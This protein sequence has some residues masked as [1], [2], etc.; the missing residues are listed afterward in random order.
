MDKDYA[1]KNQPPSLL[2]KELKIDTN[3]LFTDN[4]KKLMMSQT[5][6]RRDF[7]IKEKIKE[8]AKSK[9]ISE[10]Q[11]KKNSSSLKMTLDGQKVSLSSY[12][13]LD[14]I[15]DKCET[16]L[17]KDYAK[18]NGLNT[19]SNRIAKFSYS[20][21]F[22]REICSIKNPEERYARIKT[23]NE[24]QLLAQG[25]TLEI[26]NLPMRKLLEIADKTPKLREDSKALDLSM[27]ESS[28]LALMML[29]EFWMN[30]HKSPKEITV[31][32]DALQKYG[33]ILSGNKE[34][35]SIEKLG[36]KEILGSD[37]IVPPKDMNNALIRENDDQIEHGD[38]GPNIVEDILNATA[39]KKDLPK[40][41]DKKLLEEKLLEE[42]Q[43]QMS[44]SI[45]DD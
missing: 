34:H 3:K 14:Y 28:S 33:N 21:K 25:F 35:G 45:Y 27:L 9:G 4:D 12:S 43:R 19:S 7:F 10:E 36:L 8:Y 13:H 37:S 22:R 5:P 16:K 26:I 23:E 31:G 6:D 44:L 17:K 30:R 15:A 20:P 1:L 29:S 42:R 2:Q 38:K 11:L 32:D 41:A 18:E 24:K 39:V 40:D